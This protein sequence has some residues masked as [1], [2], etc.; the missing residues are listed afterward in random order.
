MKLM[1]DGEACAAYIR[2]S[3]VACAVDDSWP[4]D[5]L[6]ADID[7]VILDL[8]S[9]RNILGIEILGRQGNGS[10]TILAAIADGSVA[11]ALTAEGFDCPQLRANPEITVQAIG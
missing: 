7:D 9:D 3:S 5:A 10:E 1:F 11:A 2:L 4:L 6:I 8:D